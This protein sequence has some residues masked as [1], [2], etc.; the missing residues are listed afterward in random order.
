MV[1]CGAAAFKRLLRWIEMI[2][3]VTA[4]LIAA[5]LTFECLNYVVVLGLI[6]EP[7]TSTPL[8]WLLQLWLEAPFLKVVCLSVQKKP[9]NTHWRKKKFLQFLYE[10]IRFLYYFEDSFL[11]NKHKQIKTTKNLT[12]W[13]HHIPQNRTIIQLT[14]GKEDNSVPVL[15]PFVSSLLQHPSFAALSATTVSLIVLI[16]SFSWLMLRHMTECCHFISYIMCYISLVCYESWQTWIEIIHRDRMQPWGNNPCSWNCT[17]SA[18]YQIVQ[19][20][21]NV[22]SE[23]T[24]WT[25]R[26]SYSRRMWP[27]GRIQDPDLIKFRFHINDTAAQRR[28]YY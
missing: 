8:R 26:L 2:S 3:S 23:I 22:H 9:Q 14:N 17:T 1:D 7:F 19:I 18:A 25:E 21:F 27:Y 4:C 15:T 11:E 5:T 10:L 20:V 6:A 13:H 16:P 12:L 24:K 28:C